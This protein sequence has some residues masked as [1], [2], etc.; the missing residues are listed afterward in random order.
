[1]VPQWQQALQVPSLPLRP[2][3]QECRGTSSKRTRSKGIWT[4]A[5]TDC[6]EICNATASRTYVI[7]GGKQN[8]T[9]RLSWGEL[10]CSSPP[11][12]AVSKRSRVH[13]LYVC[14][15]NDAWHQ[16]NGSTTE[17][18]SMVPVKIHIIRVLT[19]LVQHIAIVL[20]NGSWRDADYK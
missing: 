7:V 11:N 5:N 18:P 10:L 9:K 4:P 16:Q 8:S 1:M 6:T 15:H 12:A 20:P 3:R 19:C 2:L 14:H 17:G 13:L